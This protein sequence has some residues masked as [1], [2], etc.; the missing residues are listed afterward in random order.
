[1]TD[2]FGVNSSLTSSTLN[3]NKLFKKI[4]VLSAQTNANVNFLKQ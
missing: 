1:M 2:F 4:S 3:L